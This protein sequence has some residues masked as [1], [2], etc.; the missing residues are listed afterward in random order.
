MST[1]LGLIANCGFPCWL[2]SQFA[3]TV[4]NMVQ[5]LLS[6][7]DWKT[8]YMV[9]KPLVCQVQGKFSCF[10]FLL[11]L[12]CGRVRAKEHGEFFLSECLSLCLHP[13]RID[14]WQ[15]FTPTVSSGIACHGHGPWSRSCKCATHV[16][17]NSPIDTSLAP[18]S[19]RMEPSARL[20]LSGHYLDSGKV[21]EIQLHPSRFECRASTFKRFLFLLTLLRTS[22]SLLPGIFHILSWFARQ[23]GVMAC[24]G[25]SWCIFKE[26][27]SKRGPL[28]TV[29][30]CS[31]KMIAGMKGR[32]NLEV[33]SH[34]RVFA[35]ETLP[36][37]VTHVC[38]WST[39]R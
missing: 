18:V 10:F 7:Y 12:C 8:V 29:D 23:T 11:K 36:R 33:V 39:D 3:E 2:W 24:E 37:G 22:S 15:P 5:L 27:T 13:P 17:V 38:F 4:Y 28:N 9:H 6:L 30:T 19:W 25:N 35:C 16:C 14:C 20:F 31:H 26:F 21:L 34:L 32:R 1:L